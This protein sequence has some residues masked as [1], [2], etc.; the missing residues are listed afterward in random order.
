MAAVKADTCNTAPNMHLCCMYVWPNAYA[1]AKV[2]A[3]VA[4]Y[5]AD[6]HKGLLHGLHSFGE[7]LFGLRGLC[8]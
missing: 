5:A 4:V 8:F 1:D 7:I 2:D 3:K 6:D